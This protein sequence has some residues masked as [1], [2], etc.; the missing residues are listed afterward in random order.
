VTFP[1]DVDKSIRS[2][3][4]FNR[5]LILAIIIVAVANIT[6]CVWF[7]FITGSDIAIGNSDK[8]LPPNCY[9]INGKQI[10]PPKS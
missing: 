3:R 8:Y 2:F 4:F 7:F 5:K 10:C 6:F 9:S 1:E